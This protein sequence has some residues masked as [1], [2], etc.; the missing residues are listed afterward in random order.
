MGQEIDKLEFTEQDF[1]NFKQRLE[2]ETRLLHEW[3]EDDHFPHTDYMGGFELEAWLLNHDLSPAPINTLFLAGMDSHL[4]TPELAKFNIEINNQPLTL[5]DDCLSQFEKDLS[6]HWI[7]CSRT[8]EELDAKLVMIG[9][10]PNLRDE[11]LNLRNMSSLKRYQALNEQVL[12][13]RGGKPLALN[14]DGHEHLESMHNDVMLEAAATSFQIHIKVPQQAAKAVYNASII[15]SAPLVAV[16]ANSPYLFGKQ[17][18]E[19]TRI[20]L[21][22]QAVEVGG[23]NDKSAGLHRRVSFGTGYAEN[24]LF[25]CFA[26]NLE[27][28]PI[29]LPIDTGEPPEKL[30]HLQLHNGTI[31]RWNR[32]LIGFS[33]N[34]KPHLRIEHRV[35]PAGPSMKDEIAN[36]AFY[37]GLAIS[38]SKDTLQVQQK[39]AFNVAKSNFYGAAKNGLNAE[40]I[41]LDGKSHNIDKLILEQLL[42]LAYAGLRQLN[43]KDDDCKHYLQIIEN[44]TLKKQNGSA[45]QRGFIKKY[46]KDFDQLMTQYIKNQATGHAIH[47]WEI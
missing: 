27:K 1:A 47:D 20:P 10:P 43:I 9:I 11:A 39:I 37:F 6:A 40:M 4:L 17:L 33:A 41:W 34:G 2:A 35:I 31:W 29:L 19:E 21:F 45:W 7:D 12:K 15:A 24:S 14:I 26:E 18:W 25:D 32:P 8:A 42:P 5:N 3:F 36:A 16:S 44:R 46:G 30:S 23:H 22:E 38:L 13:M 28:F